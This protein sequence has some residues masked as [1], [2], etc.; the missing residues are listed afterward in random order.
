MAVETSPPPLDKAN[1][2]IGLLVGDLMSDAAELVRKEIQLAKA[3][4]A[5][6]A[7]LLGSGAASLAIGALVTFAG[8]LVL[9]DAAVY[10][11]AD[12]LG[13]APAWL[14]PLIVGVVVLGVGMALLLKGR[15]DLKPEN[16]APRRSLESMRRNAEMVKEQLR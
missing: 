13:D 12:L 8:L 2:P 6:K 7:S 5:E 9:L 3:E 16:L 10:G 11:L 1:R 15:A 14:S 4:L